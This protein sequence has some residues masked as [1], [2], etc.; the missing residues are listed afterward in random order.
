MRDRE[1]DVTCIV[2]MREAP[3]SC[4]RRGGR[5]ARRREEV[6]VNATV[7]C[8]RWREMYGAR[9]VTKGAMKAVLGR[10]PRTGRALGGA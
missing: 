8:R 4:T 3:G 5:Y 10:R 9:R 1:C 6:A 2:P 7:R